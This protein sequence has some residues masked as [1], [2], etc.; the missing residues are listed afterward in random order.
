MA[1]ASRQVRSST[2]TGLMAMSLTAVAVIALARALAVME[3][4]V[5]HRVIDDLDF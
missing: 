2:A 4:V 3:S 5:P 1:S